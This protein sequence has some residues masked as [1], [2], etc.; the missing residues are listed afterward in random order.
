[1]RSPP[2]FPPPPTCA[3]LCAHNS[4]SFRP[5]DPLE[6]GPQYANEHEGTLRPICIGGAEGTYPLLPPSSPQYS[7][8]PSL[9]RLIRVVHAPSR[10]SP[11]FAT[12]TGGYSPFPA[13]LKRGCAAKR[14]S[15]AHPPSSCAIPPCVPPQPTP[16]AHVPPALVRVCG[17]R[18]VLRA[19]VNG[20]AQTK[21][22]WGGPHTPLPQRA[23]PPAPLSARAIRA[24]LPLPLPA[25]GSC[26]RG[27]G[28]RNRYVPRPHSSPSA[29]SLLTRKQGA[30]QNRSL[31][32]AHPGGNAWHK[33]PAPCSLLPPASRTNE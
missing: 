27:R 7:P 5:H 8:L 32:S 10:F 20:C 21:M 12:C 25:N 17:V 16:F 11:L 6:R 31:A 30:T 14:C 22:G 3:R 4:S 28:S 24:T 26:K 33:P 23:R 13:R 15:H 19:G 2:P 1:M 29:L 18:H 9:P